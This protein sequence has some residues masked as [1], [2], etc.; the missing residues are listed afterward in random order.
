M[1]KPYFFKFQNLPYVY[2][3]VMAHT[4]PAA[5]AVVSQYRDDAVCFEADTPSVSFRHYHEARLNHRPL[6]DIEQLENYK[7]KSAFTGEEQVVK[8]R[9]N[10][11]LDSLI[12]YYSAFDAPPGIK[13][14]SIF[15]IG[16]KK[17]FGL[18]NSEKLKAWVIKHI[19]IEPLEMRQ[20]QAFIPIC[21]FSATKEEVGYI[22]DI[23]LLKD[24]S[25]KDVDNDN[26]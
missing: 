23:K 25:E 24:N 21:L 6:C 12:E 18:K 26:F 11:I 10:K 5:Q 3:V 2:S 7:L 17:A 16:A 9:K 1:K 19:G 14:A 22:Q 4:K 20:R 15:T 13:S 8:L